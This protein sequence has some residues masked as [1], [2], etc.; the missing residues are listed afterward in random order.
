M[1]DTRPL[2][3]AKEDLLVGTDINWN[4]ADKQ[5]FLVDAANEIDSR[6][7]F[8]YGTPLRFTKLDESGVTVPLPD[9]ETS[10]SKLLIQQV[11]NRLASGH[12]LMARA[13]ASEDVVLNSYAVRLLRDAEMSICQILAG[14]PPLDADI[15]DPDDGS[16]GRVPIVTNAD[17]ESYVS[18]YMHFNQ[19]P[20]AID[21]EPYPPK[22]Y[23]GGTRG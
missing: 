16:N 3:S 11:S 5:V 22:P 17:S 14:K 23:R 6:L 4:D 12:L 18:A 1:P 2:Y 8:M 10:P 21:A 20:D 19:H 13:A 9:N 15:S 7:G